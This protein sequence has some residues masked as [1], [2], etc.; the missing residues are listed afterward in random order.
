MALKHFSVL[1][2][3]RRKEKYRTAVQPLRGPGVGQ[4]I[5]WSEHGWSGNFI[6]LAMVSYVNCG[7]S[8]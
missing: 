1:K 4:Y 5:K 8:D 3:F 2:N 7:L 6:Y